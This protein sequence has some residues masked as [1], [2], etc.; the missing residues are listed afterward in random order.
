MLRNMSSKGFI[1]YLDRSGGNFEVIVVGRLNRPCLVRRTSL[2]I[3]SHFFRH[4]IVSHSLDVFI[5]DGA[6]QWVYH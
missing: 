4:F 2:S 1:A 5:E 3:L 6:P